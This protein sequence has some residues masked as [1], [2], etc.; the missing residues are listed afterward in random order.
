MSY[1]SYK[2]LCEKNESETAYLV[3]NEEDV[4]KCDNPENYDHIIVKSS[5]P[6]LC[7]LDLSRFF[8]I[9]GLYI[10]NSYNTKIVNVSDT[11]E[12]I[13]M[14]RIGDHVYIPYKESIKYII[15][16]SSILA[17]CVIFNNHYHEHKM[18][19]NINYACLLA[20]IE[21]TCKDDDRNGYM[22]N[23]QVSKLIVNKFM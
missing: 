20:H 12:Y 9:K 18:G 1:C 4:L 13:C 3:N 6:T 23:Q 5:N 8:N 10:H 15:N 22:T 2:W 17:P 14:R 19:Y 7:E 11:I 16:F 21:Y